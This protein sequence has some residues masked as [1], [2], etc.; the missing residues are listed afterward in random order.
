MPVRTSG[1]RGMT[2][3]TSPQTYAT[4]LDTND[5]LVRTTGGDERNNG[6]HKCDPAPPFLLA[7]SQTDPGN[8]LQ[9][10]HRQLIGGLNV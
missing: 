2:I 7:E 3:H 10:T 4:S 1:P 8:S 5:L 9:L 6:I